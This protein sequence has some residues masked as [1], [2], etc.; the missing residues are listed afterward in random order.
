MRQTK[1]R[2]CVAAC[3][4]AGGPDLPL[5]VFPFILRGVTLAGIDAAW[6]P[7]ADRRTAWDRLG[8]DW[9]PRYL[10]ELAVQTDLLQVDRFVDSILQGDVSGRVIVRIQDE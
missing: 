6:Y 9:K 2:G 7:M 3:G 4:L 1:L 10:D 5:T 8:T